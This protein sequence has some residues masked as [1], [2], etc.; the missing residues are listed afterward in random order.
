MC[1]VLLCRWRT[2]W[3]WS[4]RSPTTAS[5]STA[6]AAS[7]A[8][9]PVTSGTVWLRAKVAPTRTSTPTRWRKWSSSS[10][11][12]TKNYLTVSDAGFIGAIGR[13]SCP[14]RKERLPEFQCRTIRKSPWRNAHLNMSVK[15]SASH[16]KE[17]LAEFE[18]K[19]V[20]CRKSIKWFDTVWISYKV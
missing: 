12:S 10:P 14:W 19:T 13:E 5:R 3:G 18:C 9:I 11:P 7:S 20:S 15:Q 6:R 17:R 4:T 2:S 8:S 16:P 1:R